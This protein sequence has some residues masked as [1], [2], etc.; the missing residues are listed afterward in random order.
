MSWTDEGLYPDLDKRRI[1]AKV[2]WYRQVENII[3]AACVFGVFLALGL[4]WA[5]AESKPASEPCLV[6]YVQHRITTEAR[7]VYVTDVAGRRICEVRRG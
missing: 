1:F 3:L 2:P 4:A 7:G 5:R 6:H